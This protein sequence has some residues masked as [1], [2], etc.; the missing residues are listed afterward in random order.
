MTEEVFIIE[1]HQAILIY[2]FYNNILYSMQMRMY[3][4]KLNDIPKYLT[5]KRTDQKHSIVIHEKGETLL[6]PLKLHGA[7]SY[8]TPRKPTIEEYNNFTHFSATA[9]DP[10]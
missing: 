6:I 3:D 1:V 10:E 2:Y 7:T 4:V 5:E 9:V 8:F